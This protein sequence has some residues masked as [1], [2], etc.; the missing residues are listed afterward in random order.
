MLVCEQGKS[1]KM[2][3]KNQKSRSIKLI[4]LIF[5]LIFLLFLAQLVVSHRLATAGETVKRLEVE[6]KELSEEN[7]LLKEEIGRMGSLSRISSEAAKLGL[8]RSSQVLHLTP[9]IPVA[10]GK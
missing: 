8:S 6:A 1:F 5:S 7:T 10:L 9:Q 3:S 2:R 4:W